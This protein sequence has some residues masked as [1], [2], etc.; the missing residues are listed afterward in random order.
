MNSKTIKIEPVN[1][2]LTNFT[3]LLEYSLGEYAKVHY[4]M[5]TEE[6]IPVKH[7]AVTLTEEEFS[8]WG[9]DDNY[10]ENLVLSRLNLKKA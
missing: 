8:A 7:G 5:S 4:T 9:T 2:E 3:I 10:V 6:G 1:V